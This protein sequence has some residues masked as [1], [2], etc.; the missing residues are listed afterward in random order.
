MKHDLIEIAVW[1]MADWYMVGHTCK[2]FTL[3]LTTVPYFDNFVD[4]FD[5][6][7]LFVKHMLFNYGGTYT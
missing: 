6:Y 7:S 1:Y 4:N 2:K 5:N 3:S